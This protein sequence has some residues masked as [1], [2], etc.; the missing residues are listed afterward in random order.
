MKFCF[1]I[2]LHESHCSYSSRRRA[3]SG[4]VK[5]KSKNVSLISQAEKPECSTTI[6][7]LKIAVDIVLFKLTS[8]SSSNSSTISLV[9]QPIRGLGIGDRQTDTLTG[10]K[11]FEILSEITG[12]N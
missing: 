1:A 9:D 2:L 3:C 4:R 7:S 8:T 10:T 6:Q 11:H 12:Q 5:A